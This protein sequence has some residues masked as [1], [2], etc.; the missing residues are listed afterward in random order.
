MIMLYT[1]HVLS[2]SSLLSK[3]G[4]SVATIASTL[5]L[6]TGNMS[7]GLLQILVLKA[8]ILY[9]YWGTYHRIKTSG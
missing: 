3:V 9:N 7:V 6:Q 4:S 1:T 5:F 2:V 8:K